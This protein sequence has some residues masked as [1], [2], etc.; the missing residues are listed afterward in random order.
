MDICDDGPAAVNVRR[1]S[2]QEVLNDLI[3]LSDRRQ[4]LI[5][6]TGLGIV[7]NLTIVG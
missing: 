7:T 1:R 5:D 6:Q 2:I 4:C 3:K